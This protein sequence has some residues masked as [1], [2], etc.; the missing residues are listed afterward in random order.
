[1]GER[2]QTKGAPSLVVGEPPRGGSGASAPSQPP[3]EAGGV[4]SEPRLWERARPP[5]CGLCGAPLA[6]LPSTPSSSQQAA[7]G[8]LLLGWGELPYAE[9]PEP[10]NPLLQV[11]PGRPPENTRGAPQPSPHLGLDPIGLWWLPTPLC[12]FSWFQNPLC[13]SY[14]PSPSQAKLPALLNDTRYWHLLRNLVKVLKS[15]LPRPGPGS[16]SLPAP[17][18]AGNPER[19]R[20]P[21]CPAGQFLPG[22]P[23]TLRWLR[24]TE[25]TLLW[26]LIC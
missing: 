11:F 6:P 9:P 4:S 24:G 18:G 19:V 25:E 15:L 3:G 13:G 7:L 21:P 26:A 22:K 12:P 2:L 5:V 20:F 10:R 1:M 16:T 14:H 17:P 23:H 8:G